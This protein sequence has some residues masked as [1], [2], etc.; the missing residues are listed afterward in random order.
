VVRKDKKVIAVAF[1]TGIDYLRAAAEETTRYIG[2]KSVEYGSSTKQE[3]EGGAL[4]VP[5]WAEVTVIR[6]DSESGEV[7]EISAKAFW[8]EYYPGEKLGHMWR[9]MPHLMLGKC[10][11]A[12]AL[13]KGF[14]RKLGGLYIN[15]EMEQAS[16]VPFT[17]VEMPKEKKGNEARIQ[18]SMVAKSSRKR[19]ANDSTPLP[20]RPA[21]QTTRSRNGSIGNMISNPQTTSQRPFMMKSAKRWR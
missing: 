19:S 20:K 2:Q 8:K 7:A 16:T 12:A 3:I 14:P 6:K 11:E 15:E 1:Q 21:L 10:A 9:K 18:K 5:E 17:P 4:E 13:R